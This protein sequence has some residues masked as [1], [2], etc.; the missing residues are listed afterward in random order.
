MFNEKSTRNKAIAPTWPMRNNI[1]QFRYG[2]H[3]EPTTLRSS[4]LWYAPRMRSVKVG[5]CRPRITYEYR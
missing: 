5:R 4:V 1:T 3:Y 2:N